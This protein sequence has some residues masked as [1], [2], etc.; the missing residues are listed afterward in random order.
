MKMLQL[1]LPKL[2]LFTNNILGDRNKNKLLKIILNLYKFFVKL[3]MNFKW[4]IHYILLPK[5]TNLNKNLEKLLIIIKN[6]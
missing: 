4:H 5:F 2:D 3:E 1:C 6:P